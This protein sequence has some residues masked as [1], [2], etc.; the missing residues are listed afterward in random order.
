MTDVS[1]GGTGGTGYSGWSPLTSGSISKPGGTGFRQMADGS[2]KVLVTHVRARVAG[3]SASRSIKF[4]FAGKSTSTFTVGAASHSVPLTSWRALTSPAL[5]NGGSTSLGVTMDGQVNFD[6]A[7]G[8]STQDGPGGTF[9]ESGTIGGGYRYASAPTAPTIGTLVQNGPTEA[10]LSWSTPSDDGDAALVGYR[11]EYATNSSFTSATTLD[12]GVSTSRKLTG[13]TPGTQVYARVSARNAVTEAADSSS[14]YSGS[15]SVVLAAEIGD[16]DGWQPFGTLPAGLTPLVGGGLRRGS[17]YPLGGGAPSGL[18]REINSAGSG[19]VTADALGIQRTLTGLKVG[20]TYK[21]NATVISLQASPSPANVYK[22]GIDGI[23]TA[24]AATIS[25]SIPVALPELTFIATATSHMARIYLAETAAWSSAGWWESTAFYSITLTEIPDPTPYRLQDIVYEG[26][27][28]DHFSIACDTVG[29]AW[30]VDRGNVTRFRQASSDDEIKAIFTDRRA[31]GELEYVDIQAS[32]DTRNV[33]NVLRVT[34]HGRDAGTGDANDIDYASSDDSS[35][36]LWGL[37][38]GQL[39]MSLRAG[40][41]DITNLLANASFE[42]VTTPWAL[43]GTFDNLTR[44][45]SPAAYD[46]TYQARCR[47]TGGGNNYFYAGGT[48]TYPAAAGDTFTFSIWVRSAVARTARIFLRWLDSTTSTL[49]TTF[50][51]DVTTST[52]GWTR[53]SVSGVAPASTSYVLPGINIISAAASEYHYFDAGLLTTG[54]TLHEFFSGATPDTDDLVYE[55]TATPHESTSIRRNW[56]TLNQRLVEIL[57]QHSTPEVT[58][59]SVRWNAQENPGLAAQLD[60]QDRVR[61]RH[62]GSIQDSRIVGIKHEL[63]SNR[64]ITTLDLVKSGGTS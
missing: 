22:L 63:A 57:E 20:A 33:V 36:T 64:W 24:A 40:Y 38:A 14:L 46:G 7:G 15:V 26:P 43:G 59:S 48:T 19:S 37:R 50:A 21:L 55:F 54:S 32:Y 9:N 5:C 35:V 51:A 49:A 62:R 53:L 47:S 6:R 18:L 39:D 1:F 42:T 4:T 56:T 2:R 27:L 61:V 3:R 28:H 31:P 34:N 11:I 12:I 10:T 58:I 29:A 45:T 8:G 23:G 60:I 16:L 17:V 41:I 52:S 30:W 25:G 13:L 44:Q